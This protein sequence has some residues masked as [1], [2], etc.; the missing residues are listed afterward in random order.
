[1]A[2]SL[3]G[4]LNFDFGVAA[5]KFNLFSQETKIADKTVLNCV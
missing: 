3:E 1:M 2:N 4:F 5:L